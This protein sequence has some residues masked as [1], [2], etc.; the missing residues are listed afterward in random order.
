MDVRMECSLT[1]KVDDSERL[2][3]RKV[4]VSE[5]LICYK[6]EDWHGQ[7]FVLLVFALEMIGLTL[8]QVLYLNIGCER[9]R[10]IGKSLLKIV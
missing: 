6:G 10:N 7:D 8:R 9:W 4:D 2:F 1:Q 3:I 5:L